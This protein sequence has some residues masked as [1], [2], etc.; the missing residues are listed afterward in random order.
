ML[1]Q[2]KRIVPLVALCA[3]LLAGIV[4]AVPQPARGAD[5][6]SITI[7]S[8]LGINGNVKMGEWNPLTI[9]LTSSA[10]ISGELVVGAQIPYTGG[11]ATHVQAVDLPA[12]SPK[13]VTFAV[14]G[15]HFDKNNNSIRFYE[16]T[17][18]SGKMILFTA[19]S[20][21]LETIPKNGTLVGAL[22]ADPDSLNFLRT[23][24]G[25]GG[26]VTVIPLAKEQV[27]EDGTLLSSLDVL[28]INDYSAD[29]LGEGRTRAIRSW[30][31]KGGTLVLS[32]GAGYPKSVKGFEDLSPVNYAGNTNVSALP[33]LEKLGGK[34]L[35]LDRS[36]PVSAAKLKEGAA[37]IAQFDSNPLIASWAVGQGKVIYAAYDVAME[38]LNAWNGHPEVWS[39]VLQLDLTSGSG[40]AI[41][42]KSELFSGIDGLLDYFPSMTLPPFSLLMWLLLGYAVLVAPLL[43]YILKKLD[44]R[45][46]AWALIPLI[47]V[48][49]SGGIYMAGTS[50]GTSF[51]THTFN[52]MELDGKGQAERTTASALFVPRGG[53]YNIELPAGTYVS[54]KREDGLLAG[55]QIQEP[56]RQSIRVQ[57][58][59]T[60][61]KLKDMTHRS[62]AK[63]WM[64]QPEDREFGAVSV[65][66]GFDGQGRLQGTVTNR[67]DM[68]LSDAALIV[69]E[70][71]FQLGE[72]PKQQS[73]PIASG[74]MKVL[75][76]DYGGS[77]FPYNG[78]RNQRDNMLLERQRGLV[79]SYLNALFEQDKYLFI[80]W[81]K[82]Q[83]S[84][85]KV[86]GK[87]VKSDQLNMW[88]QPFE[89][90]LG[91]NG[92]MY[93][94]YGFVAGRVLS[95]SS[96]EWG[97]ED[98][99]R[100][101]MSPGEMQIEYRLPLVPNLADSE[102]AMAVRQQD[103]GTRTTAVIWNAD[104][105]D[106]Q[107]LNWKNGEVKF[108]D[109]ANQYLQN[110]TTLRIRITAEEWTSFDIPELSLQGRYSE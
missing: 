101:N 4:Y 47:A 91:K 58:D 43:Y 102:L 98:S 36:F 7:E 51:Q 73:V 14:L 13:R 45:E 9:T 57:A 77:L 76:D 54:V 94:P 20:S 34:K 107:A 1:F 28:L 26:N 79:N 40:K 71:V 59:H 33:E 97:E 5:E 89:P 64:D 31:H 81:S 93:L 83:Q 106:W 67:T 62:F 49:A 10:D 2:V 39:S 69:G 82:E 80:A 110:G 53:D 99:G 92:E 66:A 16:G 104:K 30:V 85:Y 108:A 70:N 88:V 25:S 90:D 96:S 41:G 105:N 63:L 6:P 87:S 61:V 11:S 95:V 17:A 75:Y 32:G 3:A 8:E 68:D 27:P 86:N 38:P 12:G 109:R 22:A 44:K 52:I 60:T 21:Y 18:E 48:A 84:D 15:N 37:A 19:G 55:G 46:W 103:K 100:V 56:S 50:G 35:S 29:T 65:E 78:S 42:S 74:S 23:L 24:N 72:L